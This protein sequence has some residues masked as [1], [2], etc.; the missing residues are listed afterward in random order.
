[1]SISIWIHRHL[2][3]IVR[4]GFWRQPWF[5]WITTHNLHKLIEL[6]Q[7]YHFTTHLTYLSH[8]TFY[9]HTETYR[10]EQY[11]VSAYVTE[12]DWNQ[13]FEVHSECEIRDW[14]IV[15]AGSSLG[16]QLLAIT[17]WQL[18]FGNQLLWQSTFVGVWN[19]RLGN[20]LWGISSLTGSPSSA[21]R[22]GGGATLIGDQYTQSRGALSACC[23]NKCFLPEP[24][25][26]GILNA[27]NIN[28][29]W[30]KTR[31]S[32]ARQSTILF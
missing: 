1:M 30:S 10:G 11:R 15:C 23:P 14:V 29:A 19:R 26:G 27:K 20:C 31:T 25:S 32:E 7:S 17:F 9:L 22:K 6:L 8:L 16:N 2:Q 28:W 18:T 21:A 12:C 3:T 13:L 5:H 4:P 24:S